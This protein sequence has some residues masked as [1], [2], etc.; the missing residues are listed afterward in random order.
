MEIIK[1]D[2]EGLLVLKPRIF[3]DARGYFYE[4]YS[5]RDFDKQ[6]R[7]INFVQDNESIHPAA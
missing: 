7:T 6:V 3:E 5:K 2:I 4:S 1:T